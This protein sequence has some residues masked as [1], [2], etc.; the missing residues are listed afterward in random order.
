MKKKFITYSVIF[1]Y[2]ALFTANIFHFHHISFNNTKFEVVSEDV[3]NDNL[4]SN[5]PSLQCPVH[6][7]FNSIHTFNLTGYPNFSDIFISPKK[8]NLIKSDF[9]YNCYFYTS[10]N[11]RAPPSIFF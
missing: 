9:F 3:L 10:S 4:T 8:I 1:S 11:L 5:H 2:L 6:N 7:S